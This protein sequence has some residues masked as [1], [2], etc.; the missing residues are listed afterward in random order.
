MPR[1]LFYV[2]GLLIV[3]F[4]VLTFFLRRVLRGHA[5]V[6]ARRLQKLNE[7]N[8]RREMD[9][10]RKLDEAEK[11]YARKL[12]RADKEVLRLKEEAQKEALQLKNKIIDE[13]N[14]EKDEIIIDAHEEADSIKAVA[15]MSRELSAVNLAGEALKTVLTE[16]LTSQMHVHF[17]NQI[18]EELSRLDKKKIGTSSGRVEVISARPLS[19]EEKKRL[20]EILSE[21][22]DKKITLEEKTDHNRNIAGLYIKLGDLVIDGTINNRFNLVLN[23]I[24]DSIKV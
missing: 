15:A 6:A 22:T 5:D 12:A 11:E 17:V 19:A 18:L 24:K 8:L 14:R 21:K 7:E 23:R 9:L 3:V 16:E 1:E 20:I 4:V 13:G 2:I 10:K